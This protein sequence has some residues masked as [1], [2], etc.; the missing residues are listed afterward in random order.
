[1]SIS[2]QLPDRLPDQITPCPIIESIFEARFVSTENWATM[3]GLLYSQIRER[4]REQ[5]NLPLLQFPESIRIQEPAFAHQ[6][7][8]QFHGAKFIVQLGPRVVSLVT[9]PQAYPGWPAIIEELRWLIG[10]V[11]A[12][13]FVREAGRLGVRYVD[14][15]GGNIFPN[16]RIGVQMDGQPLPNAQNSISTVLPFDHCRTRL[17]ITDGAIV[18]TVTGQQVGSVLD[19]DA[20]VGPAEADLFDRG[21]DRFADLHH[22]VKRLFFGLLKPGFLEQLEPVYS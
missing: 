20:W 2:I 12:A 19:I 11:Q 3:P 22:T 1:M 4:Y 17:Q 18:R 6:P 14:F 13:G 9:K 21:P 10:R 7:L 5:V 16:L 15:F 8:L